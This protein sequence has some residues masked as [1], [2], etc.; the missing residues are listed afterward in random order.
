MCLVAMYAYVCV[1]LKVLQGLLKAKQKSK[2]NFYKKKK[3]SRET[4]SMH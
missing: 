3:K 2:E 4:C 1:Y